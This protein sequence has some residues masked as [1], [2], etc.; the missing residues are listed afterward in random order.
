MR[1][2]WVASVLCVVAACGAER[3]EQRETPRGDEPKTVPITAMRLVSGDKAVAPGD[4]TK[5]EIETN[6]N[7][8]VTGSFKLCVDAAGRVV[9]VTPTR[10]TGWPDYDRRII[11]AVA[12]TP[13]SP[14]SQM[15]A[16]SPCA[17]PSRSSTPSIDS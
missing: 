13:T 6:G 1:G 3:A 12:D 2:L 11:R 10:S 7:M 9:A 8:R 17:R 4:H 5:V 15:D 16:R 14:S